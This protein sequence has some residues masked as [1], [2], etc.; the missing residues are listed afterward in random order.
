[1]PRNWDD[2][3][4]LG[5]VMLEY[6]EAKVWTAIVD[7]TLGLQNG[8][9]EFWNYNTKEYLGKYFSVI[10]RYTF[11]LR[12]LDNDLIP[13]CHTCKYKQPNEIGVGCT[14]LVFN[15]VDHYYGVGDYPCGDLD[16]ISVNRNQKERCFLATPEKDIDEK[17]AKRSLCLIKKD[18]STITKRRASV[19]K[20]HF[21]LLLMIFIVLL[22]GI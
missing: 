18:K 12:F 21:N 11:S 7:G 8:Q 17:C 15:N 20:L 10:L 16:V 6:N 19:A 9:H 22:Y 4:A 2:V 1:M 5:Q 13:W 3:D 14:Y